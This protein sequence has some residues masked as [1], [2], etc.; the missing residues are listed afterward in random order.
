MSDLLLFC[1]FFFFASALL[2]RNFSLWFLSISSMLIVSFSLIMSGEKPITQILIG[3]FLTYFL[4]PK[5]GKLNFKIISI[6]AF[7][8]F[9]VLVPIDYLLQPTSETLLESSLALLVE[10]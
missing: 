3:I 9:L 2:K 7:I 5:E 10:L 6:F 8:G 4:T 1:A